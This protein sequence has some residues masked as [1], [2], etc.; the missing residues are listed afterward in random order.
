MLRARGGYAVPHRAEPQIPNTGNDAENTPA[1]RHTQDRSLI[2]PVDAP[3]STSS[4]HSLNPKKL[5]LRSLTIRS[6]Y[7]RPTPKP[8]PISEQS[9]PKCS[10]AWFLAPPNQVFPAALRSC[11][12]AP[13]P[14]PDSPNPPPAPGARSL[15]LPPHPPFPM[16]SWYPPPSPAPWLPAAPH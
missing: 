12:S 2:G 10:A 11:T 5:L 13:S 4:R 7:E 6:H 16:S 14:R 9:F 8:S 3:P 1:G 15:H